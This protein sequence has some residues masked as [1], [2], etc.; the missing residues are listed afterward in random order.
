MHDTLKQ[1]L[2]AWRRDFHRYPEQGFLEMRTASI[3]ADELARLGYRLR[4]GREVMDS[5]AIMGKPDAQTTAAHAAWARANGAVATY[6][7]A[8]EDGYT[9]V[10]ADWDSGKPGPTTALRVDMDALPIHESD[11]AEHRPQALGF[12]SQN[13]GSMHA[14]GHDGHTA[15]GLAVAT[16]L[17]E[18]RAALC[19]KIRLIFQPAEEGVRG[20]K[21]LVE[22]GVVDDVDNFIAIHLGLAVPPRGFVAGAGGFLATTKL[23]VHFHGTAA[24]AGGNPEAGKNALLAA[25]TA[26]L[27]IHA[28]ARHSEG[29]SRINVGELHAGSGRN[30]IAAHA[31]MK[32][33]TRGATASVNDYLE[34]EVRRIITAAAQMHDVAAEITLAGQAIHCRPSPQLAAT[35][36]AL[37]ENSPYFDYAQAED[38]G[39]RGSEDATWYMQR[40]QE[41]GGQATYCLIGTELAAGHHHE[42]FDINEDSLITGTELLYRAISHLNRKSA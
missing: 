10:V 6:L 25:A 40:V 38:H 30:I 34:A 9:A 7:D 8:L 15:I 18:N 4:M 27:N 3:V 41:N 36:A 24:H 29:A 17:A 35:L 22:A 26:A 23:D 33:E 21:S 32:I 31:S 37:A 5:R 14:C 19:G 13:P 42:R 2:I 39:A 16:L 12:R 11:A 1:Q 28:I 20:A